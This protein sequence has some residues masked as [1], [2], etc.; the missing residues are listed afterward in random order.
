METKN[1]NLFSYTQNNRKINNGLVNRIIDSINQIGYVKARPIIVDESFKIIDG[2]HRFEACK[3]LGLPIYYEITNIDSNRAMVL[4]NK[5]Q[6]IWRLQEYIEHW[7][8]EEIDCY[9]K[10][11]E[12]EKQYHFGVS[13]DVAIVLKSGWC[14]NLCKA[15]RDGKKIELNPKMQE[16]T[17]FILECKHLVPYWKTRHFIYAIVL[18]VERANNNDCKK[19]LKNIQAIRQQVSPNAYL[20]VFEN[21]IN[22]GKI[23]VNKISLTHEQ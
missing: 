7:A 3:Q 1:Y 8:I 13:N 17:N 16:V 6:L 5:T 20:T 21:I 9:V 11:V 19:V 2:Q 22:K 14:S 12:F 23:G 4:L 18:L 10:L 15:I